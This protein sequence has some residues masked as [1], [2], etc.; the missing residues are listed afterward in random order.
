MAEQPEEEPVIQAEEEIPYEEVS[1]LQPIASEEPTIDGEFEPIGFEEPE[2]PLEMEPV[3]PT[4]EAEPIPTAELIAA[5]DVPMA[6]E[7]EMPMGSYDVT[8]EQQVPAVRQQDAPG[9]AASFEQPI[10]QIAFTDA[11]AIE[12]FP[13]NVAFADATSVSEPVPASEPSVA[14]LPITVEQV[15]NVP[16]QAPAKEEL[17]SIPIA[18]P[19]P[20]PAPAQTPPPP[21]P[22]PAPVTIT[23]IVPIVPAK[24]IVIE[25]VV[26]APPAPAPEPAAKQPEISVDRS[27]ALNYH[28]AAKPAPERPVTVKERELEVGVQYTTE[29]LLSVPK[30]EE[31]LQVEEIK[32]YEPVME[33]IPTD[34]ILGDTETFKTPRQPDAYDAYPPQLTSE[35]LLEKT[36]VYNTQNIK[37][38]SIMT[39]NMNIDLPV[40]QEEP[41]YPQSREVPKQSLSFDDEYETAS[42]GYDLTSELLAGQ[43]PVDFTENDLF[44]SEN[45]DETIKLS[46]SK[47]YDFLGKSR[48]KSASTYKRISQDLKYEIN[49]LLRNSEKLRLEFKENEQQIAR[50]KNELMRALADGSRIANGKDLDNLQH[51]QD[52]NNHLVYTIKENDQRLRVLQTNLSNV[53]NCYEKRMFRIQNDFLKIQRLVA[54]L[55]PSHRSMNLLESSFNS[56][57]RAQDHYQNMLNNYD[58]VGF[59]SLSSSGKDLIPSSFGRYGRRRNMFDTSD[60]GTDFDSYD[61][62]GGSR[63][64]ELFSDRFESLKPDRTSDLDSLLLDDD[65]SSKF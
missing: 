43:N 33:D 42:K 50:K 47:M 36:F 64:S 38:D 28:V 22:A 61:D 40:S 44:D 27:S 17:I 6:D 4:Q 51:L 5:T 54:N 14:F 7:G 29:V 37:D 65:F 8:P 25:P 12:E 56:L 39:N 2:Q 53:Q 52:Y 11:S 21:A 10:D 45:Y 34:E 59:D 1:E 9:A 46:I 49:S 20:A 60:F 26:I 3:L 16:V 62:F 19:A 13:E 57:R 23:P 55:S 31:Q 32:S 35:P 15:L 63:T 18:A 48:Q 41:S 30:Q 24:P 58:L